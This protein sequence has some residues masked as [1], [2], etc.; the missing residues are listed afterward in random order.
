MKLKSYHR[1]EDRSG[2][3]ASLEKLALASL[4]LHQNVPGGSEWAV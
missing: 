4:D 2:W 1:R 3:Q